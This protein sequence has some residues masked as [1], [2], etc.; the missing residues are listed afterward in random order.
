MKKSIHAAD[1]AR[2]KTAVC[3]LATQIEDAGIDDCWNATTSDVEAAK[4]ARAKLVEALEI[5]RSIE[6]N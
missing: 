1:Y 5:L 2:E 4:Q 6:S 3:D